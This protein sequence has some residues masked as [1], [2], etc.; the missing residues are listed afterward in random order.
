MD[1]SATPKGVKDASGVDPMVVEPNTK[2]PFPFS[3]IDFVPPPL[4]NDV[5]QE[6]EIM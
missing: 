6:G 4:S 5:P 3:V 2:I 1:D